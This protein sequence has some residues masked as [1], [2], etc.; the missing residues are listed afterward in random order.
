MSTALSFSSDKARFSGIKKIKDILCLSG[1]RR[2]SN[3][4]W[5]GSRSITKTIKT[6]LLLFFRSSVAHVAALCA[7]EC[8][9]ASIHSLTNHQPPFRLRTTSRTINPK[10]NTHHRTSEAILI[11]LCAKLFLSTNPQTHSNYLEPSRTIQPYQTSRTTHQTPSN[12]SQTNFEPFKHLSS[13]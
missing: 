9:R 4:V 1:V 2:G 10:N 7:C 5:W 6:S 11:V 13:T 3:L 8:K 12:P